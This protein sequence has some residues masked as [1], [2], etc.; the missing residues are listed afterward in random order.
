MAVGPV[1]PHA[2]GVAVYQRG[3]TNDVGF[4]LGDE[5]MT[6]SGRRRSD[7]E[8]VE[9]LI[10]GRIM[11]SLKPW[12]P[13][14]VAVE[15]DVVVLTSKM[16]RRI[17]DGGDDDGV[18]GKAADDE[19]DEEDARKADEVYSEAADCWSRNKRR[20]FMR[21]WPSK[22]YPSILKDR[23]STLATTALEVGRFERISQSHKR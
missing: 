15:G 5:D 17:D 4:L 6:G 14:V 1:Q 2:R 9:R 10:V 12:C 18:D 11:K 8:N 23:R 21:V 19:A 22:L 3:A 13:V 16:L 7:V 20:T